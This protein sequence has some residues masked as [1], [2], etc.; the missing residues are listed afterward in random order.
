MQSYDDEQK[1]RFLSF[2]TGSYRA[3]VQG[4]A[5]LK[6]TFLRSGPDSER[7]PSAQTC[8]NYF[9]IPEYSSKEKLEA[10]LK[11]ALANE[12]GFGLC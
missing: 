12:K 9:L 10:K 2:T 6:I 3:P 7:I 4:L 5:S 11:I 1:K 8:F